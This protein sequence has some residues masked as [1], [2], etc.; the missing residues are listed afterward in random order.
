M[1]QTLLPFCYLQ[2]IP[3]KHAAVAA[4]PALVARLCPGAA[5][6]SNIFSTSRF[7]RLASFGVVSPLQVYRL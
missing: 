5:G 6:S 4:I 1:T 3:W 7:L 2:Q